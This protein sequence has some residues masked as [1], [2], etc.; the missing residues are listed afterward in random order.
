LNRSLNVPGKNESLFIWPRIGA[1]LAIDLTFSFLLGLC[2]LA[3]GQQKTAEDQVKAAYLL[4]FAKLAEWPQTALPDG[5][6]PLMIGVNG[7]DEDFL[8]VLRALVAGKF[9]GTHPVEVNSV[10]SVE[11]MKSCHIVFF[12]ASERKHIQA[13][14]ESL[15][16]TGVLFVG[17]DESLF[18]GSIYLYIAVLFSFGYYEI[19]RASGA[20]YSWPD[21]LLTSV[22]IPFFISDLPKIFAARLLGGIQCLLVVVIGIGTIVNFLRSKL[23]AVRRAAATLSD[24]FSDQSIRDKYIVLE[25][26]FSPGSTSAPHA[27]SAEK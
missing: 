22:F 27:G 19:A 20:S 12:R 6:S 3:L 10:G 15:P 5:S 18:F 13:T 25:A 9:V 23:D 11:E 26:R 14:I 4:N 8:G 17:E 7:G 16:Q 21:A 24:R 2:P 1:A